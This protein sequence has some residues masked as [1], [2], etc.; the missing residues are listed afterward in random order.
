[1]HALALLQQIKHVS[2]DQNK[3]IT[4][5]KQTNIFVSR[6]CTSCIEIN[7]YFLLNTPCKYTR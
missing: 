5:N 6:T 7:E 1:V 3:T 4:T 2:F